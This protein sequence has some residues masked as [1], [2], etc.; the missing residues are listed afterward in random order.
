MM[1][2]QIL[3]A[4]TAHRAHETLLE[5][6]QLIIA[7]AAITAAKRH[8]QAGCKD[9]HKVLAAGSRGKMHGLAQVRHWEFHYVAW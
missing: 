7:M 1:P 9:K 8:S 4:V 6:G 2:R 3:L 5:S